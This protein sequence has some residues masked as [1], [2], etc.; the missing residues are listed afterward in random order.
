MAD[1]ETPPAESE[2]LR[3]VQSRMAR[4]L[5]PSIWEY[6]VANALNLA[7]CRGRVPDAGAREA[8][9]ILR[10]LDVEIADFELVADQ[11]WRIALEHRVTIYDASY[12]ALART[13]GCEFCTGDK[14]LARVAAKEG[15]ARWAGNGGALPPASNA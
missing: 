6:E 9:A 1:E 2:L 3:S 4:L 15:V 5:A 14:R 13:R 7:V 8:L 12:V 10:G 11:A